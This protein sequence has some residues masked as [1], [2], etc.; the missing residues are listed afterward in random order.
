VPVPLFIGKIN[1]R[2]QIPNCS[3]QQIINFTC[4]IAEQP[5]NG[6]EV[7]PAG[8]HQGQ[9]VSFVL[10]HGFLVRQDNPVLVRL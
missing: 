4:R 5:E 7:G 8:L 6:A 1:G 3:K 2:R 10:G 9:T